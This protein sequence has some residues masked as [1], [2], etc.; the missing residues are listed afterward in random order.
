MKTAFADKGSYAV[1]IFMGFQKK[2]RLKIEMVTQMLD[3]A[4]G[5]LKGATPLLHSD[6]GQGVTVSN[7][8]LSG[9]IG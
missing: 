9:E 7:R 6:Q 4:F 2:G 5:R 1:D 3:N 8:C